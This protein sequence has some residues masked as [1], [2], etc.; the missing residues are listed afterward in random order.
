[1]ASIWG[2]FNSF[3]RG[4]IDVIYSLVHSHGWAVVLFTL[5]IKLVLTPFDVKSRRSMRK[6]SALNPKI[7]AQQKKYANDKEKLQQNQA[8]LYKKEKINPLAG[9]LPMLLTMPVLFA[10]FAVMRSVANEELARILLTIHNAVGT[11][12]DPAEIRAALDGL[13]SSGAL[14]FENWLWIKN[15]WMADSPFASVLP[16]NAT[17][18]QLPVIAGLLEQTQ[19]DAIKAFMGTVSYQEVLNYFNA[20]PL[21]GATINLIVF[22]LTVYRNP[23]GYFILPILAA[24]TQYLSSVLTPMDASQQTA[25]TGQAQSTGQMMKIFMPLFSVWICSTSNAAF[26]LY[27]VVTNIFM[28]AEQWLLNMYFAAQDRKAAANQRAKEAQEW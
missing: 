22:Q 16:L 14:R 7:Q 5:L 21:P 19:L 23:N 27:W 8:E 18:V 6:M 26:S 1:M 15:L 3:L 2:G 25:Q 10:M 28:M 11:L 20:V 17:A 13:T 4:V 24:V 9:C 12:T